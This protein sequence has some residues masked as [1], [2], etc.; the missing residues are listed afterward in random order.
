MSNTNWPRWIYASTSKYFQEIADAYPILMYIEGVERDTKNESKWLEF[1]M[2]GPQTREISK[3]Y[4]RLDVEINILW[5]V[6]LDSTDFHEQQ[7]ISGMLIEAMT[8]IC[9]YKYGNGV[10]DDDS[11]LGTLILQQDP[12]NPVR[13]NNF[14][15]VRSDTQL[16]QGSVEGTYRMYLSE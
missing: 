4:F 15:Q 1:R 2:D 3:N 9:V 7:R 16:V 6:H 13:D 12:N 11:L 10:V 8:D 5:S 14:G